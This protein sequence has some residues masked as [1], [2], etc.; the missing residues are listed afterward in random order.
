MNPLPAQTNIPDVIPQPASFVGPPMQDPSTHLVNRLTNRWDNL[1]GMMQSSHFYIELLMIA[2]ALGLAYGATKLI[3]KKVR[4]RFAVCP[5]KSIDAIFITKPLLMLG[6]IMALLFLW[7]AQMIAIATAIGGDFTGGIM[8]LAYSFLLIECVFLVVSARPVAYFMMVAILT[9]AIMHAIRINRSVTAYLDS[10]AFDAGKYHITLMHLLHGFVIFV[11]VFWGAGTLSRTLESYLRRSTKLSYNGRELAVKFFKLFIYIIAFIITLSAMGIDLT[12]FAVF[13]GALGV[14]VGLGLQK[15]TGNFVS[16]VT[17]L[18]EKSIKI[19]DLIEVGGNT[20]WVR[21]LNIR[22]AL[23]ETF[24]GREILIPNEELISTRVINWTL[25]S[26]QARI[27][28]KL[29]INF[30]SDP[31]KAQALML[32]AAQEH[33]LCLK[34]PPP[35][36]WLQDINGD[37][38]NFSLTFWIADV[39]GGRSAPQ[40]DVQFAILKKFKENS[41]ALA[42]SAA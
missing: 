38:I 41:I 26:T 21:Q 15:L 10:I 22:Y 8:Q 20:G 19:G 30:E 36:C 42:K 17:M 18:M 32:A 28:I 24:D 12:V 5:P 29:A 16:G 2:L 33:P 34:E 3:Q 23:I 31:Q 1:L 6:P 11:A 4:H 7:V 39:K 13:S 25:T 14:G 27:E 37:G 9:D 35:S 40:S